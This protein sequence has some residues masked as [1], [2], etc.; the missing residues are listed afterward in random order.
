MFFHVPLEE[1][2]VA[3]HQSGANISGHQ[4]EA[5]SFS[6]GEGDL[7]AALKSRNDVKATFCGHDHTNDYCV[8]YQGI[9]LCYEG[10]PGYQAYGKDGW[11]RRARVTELRKF[12][13]EVWSWKRLDDAIP[14]G[15]VVDEEMLWSASGPLQSSN[16]L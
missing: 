2:F 6:A 5:V 13:A 15:T 11:S 16:R 8:H 3:L 9:Q 12:G 4:N 10:S 7:F 14:A 1:Y